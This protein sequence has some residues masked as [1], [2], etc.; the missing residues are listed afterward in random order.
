MLKNMQALAFR[1]G[2]RP[3]LAKE[4]LQNQQPIG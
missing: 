2:R 3:M 1:G 4:V